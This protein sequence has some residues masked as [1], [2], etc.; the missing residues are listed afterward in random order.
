M[1]GF[2]L[3]VIFGI[4]SLQAKK[5]CEGRSKFNTLLTDHHSVLEKGH[6]CF[7]EGVKEDGHS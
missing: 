4:I 3:G 6:D 1:Q 2:V 7:S 5:T